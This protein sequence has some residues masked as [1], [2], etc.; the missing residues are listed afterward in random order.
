VAENDHVGT[1]T[2]SV[3]SNSSYYNGISAQSLTTN[4]K[5]NDH[6][7]VVL[8]QSN[9]DTKVA[10]GD[11]TDL[12]TLVL[13]S[14]PTSSVTVNVDAGNQLVSNPSTVVFTPDNWNTPQSVMI[15]AVNDNIAEGNHTGILKNTVSSLDSFY[16][17]FALDEVTV[18][19]LDD[20]HAGMTLLQSNNSTDVS[21]SGQTDTYTIVLTSQPVADVTVSLNPDDQVQVSSPSLVFNSSNWNVA[22][23]VSITAIDD[24][25]NEHNHAGLITH[26]VTSN[27][28]LYN[29]FTLPNVT[30][31]I[32]DN[33]Q[34]KFILTESNGTT[35]VVKGGNGDTYSL[36]INVAPTAP[37]IVNIN[38]SA[39]LI[40]SPTS[41]KFT[42]VNWNEVKTIIVTAVKGKRAGNSP[43]GTISHTVSSEDAQYNDLII[44]TL[45]V[46]VVIGNN[47]TDEEETPPAGTTTPP[48]DNATPP[49]IN[50]SPVVTPPPAVV[51]GPISNNN[52]AP[53]NNA[54]ELHGSGEEIAVPDLGFKDVPGTGKKKLADDVIDSIVP[55]LEEMFDAGTY[56]IPSNKTLDPYTTTKQ[57]FATQIALAVAGRSCGEDITYANCAAAAMGKGD[58]PENTWPLFTKAKSAQSNVTTVAFLEMLLKAAQIPLIKAN[59][60][61]KKV[62]S[63]VSSSSPYARVIA[64]AK[65]Y[66]ILVPT[67]KNV[68]APTK[69]F[70]KYTGLIYAARVLDITQEDIDRVNA[71]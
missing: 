28:P 20:D 57:F 55:V 10:E 13:T 39:N 41:V 23:T 40:V 65:A 25:M 34:P 17:K 48:V 42:K 45:H 3:S 53:K 43:F 58:D 47:N 1:I 62:C 52:S 30:A 44:P 59:Q 29:G 46:N 64:T 7:S 21:E 24:T 18:G 16:D 8:T 35:T 66:G 71:E 69:T 36:A 11:T 56:E 54:D 2:H 70:Q 4:I 51:P 12:Y 5:D 32:A 6:A 61:P 38:P 22:Q 31:N 63:D 14:Q 26:S 60:L 67:S 49:V 9:S 27:D 50:P 37:I 15:A 68:C 33:D 19:I